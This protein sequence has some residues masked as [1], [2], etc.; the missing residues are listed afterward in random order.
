MYR[1]VFRLQKG[2]AFPDQLGEPYGWVRV[3]NHGG[4]PFGSN[5]FYYNT[6]LEQI[7]SFLKKSIFGCTLRIEKNSVYI[8][9]VYNIL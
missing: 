2:I 4:S 1:S 9:K 6:Q 7:K 5:W 3:F 8:E